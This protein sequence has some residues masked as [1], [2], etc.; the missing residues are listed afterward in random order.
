MSAGWLP[1]RFRAGLQADRFMPLSGGF[2]GGPIYMPGV[3]RT[4]FE[5]ATKGYVD[6]LAPFVGC[7]IHRTT[8]QPV[9]HNTHTAVLWNAE[10]RD[11]HAFHDLA[12]NPD[13]VTIP[14][15]RDGTYELVASGAFATNTTGRR[16]LSLDMTGTRIEQVALNATSSTGPL[17]P[18]ISSG[19]VAMVAGDY[20]QVLAYQDSGGALD[21]ITTPAN[22]WAALRKVAA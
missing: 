19:P 7:R 6:G 15:G 1:E 22:W 14:E 18:L 3:P 4:E 9:P 13:R 10:T 12:T 8:A 16:V 5:V 17:A 11:T 20:F 2:M 21:I